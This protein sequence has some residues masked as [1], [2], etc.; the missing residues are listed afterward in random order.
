MDQIQDYVNRPK[1]YFN[2]DGLGE[3]SIGLIV[4]AFPLC[5]WWLAMVTPEDSLWQLVWLFLPILF[6]VWTPTGVEAVR[7][8]ITYPRTGFAQRRD[9]VYLKILV[10]LGLLV[11]LFLPLWAMPSLRNLNPSA[12]T[13]ICGVALAAAYAYEIARAVRWKWTVVLVLACGSLAV[14]MLGWDFYEW[15]WIGGL[16]AFFGLAWVVS[17]GITFCQYLRH[18]PAAARAVE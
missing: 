13:G 4:L 1:Q 5:W 8:R 10:L 18:T 11:L 7:K 3:V 2:I 15:G 14:S 6:M 9:P 12:L 17:G 16:F